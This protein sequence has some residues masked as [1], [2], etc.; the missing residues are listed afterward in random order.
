MS[1]R[2]I[3]TLKN[4]FLEDVGADIMQFERTHILFFPYEDATNNRKL[5]YGIH[6]DLVHTIVQEEG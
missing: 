4:G 6:A 2:F 5:E 3:L 1:K